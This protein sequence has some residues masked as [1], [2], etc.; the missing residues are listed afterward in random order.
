[1][2]DRECWEGKRRETTET[3]KEVA[4]TAQGYMHQK[5]LGAGSLAMERGEE[6]GKDGCRR[7]SDRSTGQSGGS[8]TPRGVQGDP[9][10]GAEVG[11]PLRGQGC[12]DG[13][14]MERGLGWSQMPVDR[15][16]GRHDAGGGRPESNAPMEGGRQ[17]G[18]E[19]AAWV[20][21]RKGGRAGGRRER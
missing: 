21:G 17:A 8:G 9:G 15:T 18:G 20:G 6:R 13:C 4:G 16:G 12:W 7:E 3:W 2:G 5:M 14:I 10:D 1:M 11:Q 19:E